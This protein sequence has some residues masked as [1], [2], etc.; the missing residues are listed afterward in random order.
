[1]TVPTRNQAPEIRTYGNWQKPRT[2]GIGPLGPI[3]TGIFLIGAVVVF[4]VLTAGGLVAALIA[5]VALALALTPITVTG[6]DGRNGYAILG[7]RLAHRRN[8]RKG[9]N[10]YA[11]GTLG[12]RSTPIHSQP[13][14][15]PGLLTTTALIEQADALGR[16]FG[17]VAVPH[18][19]HYSVLLGCNP[20]A[21][22]LV[23]P[24]TV[25]LWVARWG[26]FL[27]DLSHEP[28]LIGAS[29]TVDTAPDSGEKLSAEVERLT[30]DSAPDLARAV[31][32]EAAQNWPAGSATVTTW[33]TLTWSRTPSISAKPIPQDRLINQI[34]DRLPGLC[35]RLQAAGCGEVTPMT[36]GEVTALVSC[37]Y[38]PETRTGFEELGAR[39]ELPTIPWQDCGPALMKVGWDHLRH[40]SAWSKVW[41][42]TAAPSSP[43][44]ATTLSSL[45]N[46]H[47]AL[48]RKR[49]TVQYRPHSPTSAATIADR[50]VR[51]ARS[52]AE[53]RK[54]E[55]RATESLAVAMARQTADEQAAGAGLVRFSLLVT[56]T[57][58][59]AAGLETAGHVIDQLAATSR[60][61]L[62]PAA[63]TQAASFVAGLGIGMVLQHQVRL[64]GFLRDNL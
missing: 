10:V 19:Q 17:I 11:P 18:T 33:V 43:V 38:S 51:T 9:R 60:V 26:D 35:A 6:A 61:R 16:C 63:G 39:D 12:D 48:A 47:N 34:A 1:M 44:P 59:E 2:A 36:P 56:V 3:G 28:N 8:C 57:V 15:L 24:D 52:R 29:V 20:E 5:F 27:A 50:D 31:L 7:A 41:R 22:S 32:N 58:D 54:G 14:R 30:S 49:V 40:D 23:D 55:V 37:A 64:P 46:A 45:L 42:M 25:D 4:V 13:L 62:R 21:G 53:A